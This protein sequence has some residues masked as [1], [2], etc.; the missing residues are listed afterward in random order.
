MQVTVIVGDVEIVVNVQKG[1]QTIKWLASI[2]ENRL[3]ALRKTGGVS[4]SRVVAIEN[5][6]E[7]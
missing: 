2:V 1:E 3:I 7:N 4:D 5:Q 6:V